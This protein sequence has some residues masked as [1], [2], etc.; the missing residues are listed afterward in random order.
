MLGILTGLA[1]EAEIAR[2]ISPLVAC[3][4]SDPA[5]AERLARDLA[6]QGA[7]AL[8]SFGIAGGLAPELA[9]EDLVIGSAVATAD[10][11]YAC[12]AG[13]A[14][15]LAAALPG[16]V[17]GSVWGGDVIV[18]T[19]AAKARLHRDSGAVIVD[20]E[21]AAVARAAAGAGLPFGVLRAVADPAAHGLPPAALVGLDA[22]GRPAIGPVLRA[23]AR[24]PGQLPALIRLGRQSSAAMKAL[25][26]A[27]GTLGGRDLRGVA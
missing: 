26:A 2:R 6:G 24:S 11:A 13:L 10:A 14:G 27:A 20:L 8:L 22:E 18:D 25:L 4:A 3:S 15:R 21:S 19:A 12:D 1:R 17:Q 9:T 23:L 7:T 16:A 5:R